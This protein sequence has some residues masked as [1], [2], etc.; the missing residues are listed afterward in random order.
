MKHRDSALVMAV[1]VFVLLYFYCDAR[2][3]S[4]A[5]TSN[6][7][8]AFYLILNVLQL[9]QPTVKTRGGQFVCILAGRVGLFHSDRE[10]EILSTNIFK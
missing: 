9:A 4:A 8:A 7:L 3:T 1:L 2:S 6:H 10:P 5:V